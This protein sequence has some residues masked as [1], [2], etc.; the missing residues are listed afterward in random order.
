MYVYTNSYVLLCLAEK[1]ALQLPL[2]FDAQDTFGL[3][4]APCLLTAD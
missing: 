2:G 1:L 4:L 3:V